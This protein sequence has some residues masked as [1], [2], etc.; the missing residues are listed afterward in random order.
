ILNESKRLAS[1]INN[2]LEISEIEKANIEFH[3][4]P[5][6]INSILQKVKN[7]FIPQAEE[8]NIS[9]IISMPTSPISAIVNE[10]KIHQLFSNLISNAIKFTP[11]GGK[12]EAELKEENDNFLFTVKDNGIGIPKKDL[13]KIFTKFFRVHRPGF[14]FR[15]TGIGLAICHYIVRIHKG[16]IFVESQENKGSTFKVIIPKHYEK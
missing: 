11:S 6:I 4:A 5:T 15:G 7:E 12:V 14:E 10:D 16:E 8:K 13:R 9:L 2:L 3:K 1:L